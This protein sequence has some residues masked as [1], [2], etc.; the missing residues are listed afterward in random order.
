MTTENKKIAFTLS[1][2]GAKGSFQ[3]GVMKQLKDKGITPDFIVGTSIGALNATGYSY[4]GAEGLI[5]MWTN[6]GGNNNAL[7][8]RGIQWLWNFWR[9]IFSN[10]IYKPKSKGII[11]NMMS[12]GKKFSE[13]HVCYVDL[14]DGE[15]KYACSKDPEFVDAAVASGVIPLFIQTDKNNW[16]DGGVREHTP[17][18]KAI[19]L[20][21]DEIHV[22]VCNKGYLDSWKPKS[23]WFPWY[24]VL[25]RSVNN[26]MCHEIMLNDL[27]IAKLYNLCANRFED[28]RKVKIIVYY[29]TKNW[30][31]TLDFNSDGIKK[32]IEDG[33]SAEGHIL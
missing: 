12:S 23:K 3:A 33:L 10:G 9:L 1:G 32:G 4:L 11:K 5:D 7:Y 24:N 31:A 25:D 16:V 21:A 30:N 19:D 29:S 22:I 14:E 17:L 26:I 2:G 28:K 13:P 20:G 15:T 18:K 8:P 27:K 6:L